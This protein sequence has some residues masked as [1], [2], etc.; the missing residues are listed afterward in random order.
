M[1]GQHG[2]AGKRRGVAW[3][4]LVQVQRRG[5][6]AAAGG[7]MAQAAGAGKAQGSGKRSAAPDGR[8]H[9]RRQ[10]AAETQGN[11]I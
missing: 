4:V 2:R 9:A 1:G 3:D 11:C 5:H 8:K 10:Y 7:I 6:P